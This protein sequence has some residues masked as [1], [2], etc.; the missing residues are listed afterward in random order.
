MSQSV[1]NPVFPP[2]R[3]FLWSSILLSLFGWGGL[4]VLVATT[5][6]TLGPRWLFFFLLLSGLSGTTLP[7]AYYL[8]LRFPSTPPADGGS[9]LREAMLVG[10][11]GCLV[12]WLQ[13]GRVLTAPLGV[14][15]ALGFFLIEFFIRIRL[16]SLWRPKGPAD[17]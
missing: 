4:A 9:I 17:E 3:S 10:I 8:N 11:Y 15:L 7:V 12:I 6:P 5:L 2:F 16:V 13:Q 1:E 14:V